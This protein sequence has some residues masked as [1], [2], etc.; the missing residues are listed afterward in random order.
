LS[1][2]NGNDCADINDMEDIKTIARSR[3]FFI[4]FLSIEF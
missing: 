1:F 2:F 3:T 4:I